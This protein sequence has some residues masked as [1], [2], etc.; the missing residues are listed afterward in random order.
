[1]DSQAILKYSRDKITLMVIRRAILDADGN[2]VEACD[3]LGISRSSAY[4]LMREDDPFWPED[5][6]RPRK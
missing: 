6:G 4:E 1:M 5:K 3:K 2:I